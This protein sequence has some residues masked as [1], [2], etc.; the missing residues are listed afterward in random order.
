MALV[1]TILPSLPADAA[2]T[3]LEQC[4]LDKINAARTDE[5]SAPL[6][7]ALDIEGYTRD[8]SWDM[9]GSGEIIHSTGS[10]LGTVVPPS[11]TSWGENIGWQSH[12]DPSDCTAMHNAFMNSTGHRD[13][14]LNPTFQFAATGTI[15]DNN[16]ELWT[17][18][19]FFSNPS[20]SPGFNEVFSDDDNSSFEADIEAIAA[21]GITSG[22]GGDLFCLDD[23]VTR[24]QM[25]AFI[26]RALGLPSG[27]GAG[28]ND[29]TGTF[30][31]DINAI[32]AAGI[33][34]G[35]SPGY[36]CPD[37]PLTRAQMAAFMV[38]AFDLPTGPDA[39]FGDVVG[40]QFINEINSLTAAGV[41]FGCHGGNDFC[42][43]ELVTRGQ[44]AAFLARAL[45]L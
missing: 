17:T 9:S 28:F 29:V 14:L 44:M 41:T 6:T 32:A 7:W 23:L 30:A 33:T 39:G 15:L 19:V 20:Y 24:A 21:V 36:F 43:G 18:H 45:G 31:A 2:P 27:P 38:R 34:Q 16:G 25:A 42:P 12:P 37:A 8:H 1:V 5:G 11:W 22:C 35:C 10:A 4:F 26:N 3:S 13:N 40:H